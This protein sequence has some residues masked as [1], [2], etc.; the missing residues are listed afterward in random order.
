[1][2]FRVPVS[3][4]I[5]LALAPAAGAQP[6]PKEKSGGALSAEC[7]LRQLLGT[8]LTPALIKALN[9]YG[10][11]SL[12]PASSQSASAEA[13]KP[14]RVSYQTESG[15]WQDMNDFSTEEY[16]IGG[17]ERACISTGR[18]GGRIASRIYYGGQ[19]RREYAC[20][21]DKAREIKR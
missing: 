20:A 11:R 12:V 1:M 13:G 10:E 6:A 21:N 15:A 8:K 9:C 2:N 17:A 4:C 3:I 5:A 14:W 19:I 18:V 16:A 7:Y